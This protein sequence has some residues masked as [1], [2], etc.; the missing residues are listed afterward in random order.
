MRYFLTMLVVCLL[1]SAAHAELTTEQ[2]A[3][4]IEVLRDHA[5]EVL[6]A[7][8]SGGTMAGGVH[9]ANNAEQRPPAP[10]ANHCYAPFGEPR[11]D[12]QHPNVTY[13]RWKLENHPCVQ[14]KE[15]GE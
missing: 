9:Q 15:G 8:P 12:P 13:R 5:A 14:R 3:A 10:D 7:P 6:G 1:A 4:A 2:R 11:V